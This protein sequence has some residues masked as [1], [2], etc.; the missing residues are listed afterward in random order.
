MGLGADEVDALKSS[1]DHALTK[2]SWI[3][4]AAWA[5]GVV[6]NKKSLRYAGLG[7]ALVAFGVKHLA[8]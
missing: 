7:G 5:L 2:A 6:T 1:T 8:K 4:L 3:S